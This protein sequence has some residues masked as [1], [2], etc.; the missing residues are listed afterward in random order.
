M[1]QVSDGNKSDLKIIAKSLI[2]GKL[3]A[4]PTETVYGLAANAMDEHAIK[5]LYEVKGRPKNHPVI[6]HLSKIELIKFWAIEIP[7][8]VNSLITKFW[9]GPL[10]II[11]KRSNYA[12]EWITG[13]QNTVGIR[14]PNH[15]KTL[16]LL[17]EFH[18]LGGKGLAAPSANKFGNV[19]PTSS[20]DV[21]S[22]IGMELIDSDWVIEGGKSEIGIESTIV[23]CSEGIP[24]IIRPGAISRELI[25]DLCG[26]VVT[27]T[28]SEI[29]ELNTRVS[30]IL[31]KHYSPR[32]N[33]RIA[34]TCIPGE[35]FIAM[36][37]IP[38]PN[39]SIRLASPINLEDFAIDLYSSLRKAD[40]LN[41]Q[42][43]VIVPP[44]GEGLAVAIRD[45]I[46]RSA[47][48]P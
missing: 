16:Q 40:A 19:S 25:S 46:F 3:V 1:P 11:L 17:K 27:F 41:L 37:Q 23:D 20:E 38:S 26:P 29:K 10:T 32:A 24:K 35:G 15:K 45:R 39:G 34:N 13:G 43:V 5:R 28:Q 18:F 48:S 12:G 36:H 14:M 8:Y 2:E 4:I 30:G 42:S 7:E 44:E 6:V 47:G 22:D 9:P 31:V 21:I 33:V